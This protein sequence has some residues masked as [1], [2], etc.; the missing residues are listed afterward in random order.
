MT[1]TPPSNAAGFRTPEPIRDQVQLDRGSSF[2]AE[3]KRDRNHRERARTVQPLRRLI[4]FILRYPGIILGFL[5][6][7][8][9]SA[10]L[11]LMLPGAFRLVVDCGFSG[12][13]TSA[14]CEAFPIEGNLNIY[15]IVGIIGALL[16]GLTSAMRFF[17]ISLLGERVVADLRAR[18]YDH[19]LSLSPG[20]YATTRTGEVLSRL[21]T[22]TTLI[23]TVVGSSISVAV[24]TV[25]TTSG[26]LVLMFITSWQ[27]ALLMIFV[28]PVII[29]PIVLFGRRVQRL[30]RSGQDALAEASARASESLRAIDTVQAFTRE[31][32]ERLR[33]REA[34]ENTFHV[35]LRRIRVRSILTASLFSFVLAGLIGVLWYG[36]IQVQ[37][38][39]ITPGTMIQFVMYLSLIHI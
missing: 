38:G 17:F 39:T 28:A 2:A 35:A 13:A 9:T 31:P 34:V 18:V 5:F 36:A 20:Y 7:L 4:P 21:T 6:F 26:A 8:V 1:E 12:A 16:L 29:L 14:A 25:A 32:E 33:F 19:L 37:A 15:F 10:A 3:L 24:R 30:S 22:D 11:T 23:Q 27:L